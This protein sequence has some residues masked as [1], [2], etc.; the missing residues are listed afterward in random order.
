MDDLREE[1]QSPVD[2]SHSPSR[3]VLAR[4]TGDD[5]TRRAELLGSTSSDRQ[6][7]NP[8]DDETGTARTTLRRDWRFEIVAAALS[9]LV[10]LFFCLHVLHFAHRN[11]TDR[12][13]WH[14]LPF[15]KALE[16]Q[17]Y[18]L[19]DQRFSRRGPRVPLSRD[20]IAIVA[21]DQASLNRVGQWPW[22]RAMHARL[23]DRLNKAGASVVALDFD[24]SDY[25]KLGDASANSATTL[26]EAATLSANDRALVAAA[27]RAGNVIAPS[28]SDFGQSDKETQNVQ[29][30]TNLLITPFEQLDATMPDLSLAYMPLDSDGGARRYTWL[31]VFQ[32]D[33]E[34]P[35]VLG[36]FAGLAVAMHQKR[37]DGNENKAYEKALL[38]GQAQTLAGQTARVPVSR[39]RAAAADAPQM[40]TTLVHYWG[41]AGAFPT[42]SYSDVLLSRDGAYSDAA[43]KEKFAGRIVFVGATA[44]ILKDLF[45]MPQIAALSAG[46][47]TK[48]DERARAMLP[49]VELHATAAAMFLDGAF[50]RQASIGITLAS[51]FALT[52]FASLLIVLAREPVNAGARGFQTFWR[53]RNLPGRVY[54][55]SWFALYA[56]IA[57]VPVAL[58]WQGARWLFTTQN[59][60]IIVV[61]PALSAC[62]GAGGVL[63]YLFGTEAAERR[64]ALTHFSRMVSP[65]VM[66]E[67][68]A[69]P[70]EELSRPRRVRAT[71]LFTDLEG[72]TTYS[73]NHEPEEVIEALNDYLDRLVPVV[74]EYGGTID[75][76]IGDA[77]MAYFGAPVPRWDHAAQA[78]HCAIALQNEC[79][80][81]REETGIPFYMRV[82]VHTGDVI[83]GSV[84]SAQRADYTVI[85]DTV[86]LASRLEGKNKE[87]GSWIMCSTET[88]DAAPDVACVESAS[89][90]IKGK[91]RAVDVYIVRG[92]AGEAPRDKY[93]GR[94]LGSC[95]GDDA[96]TREE[97]AARRDLENNREH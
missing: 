80:R 26:G 82:G 75:K 33:S 34:T 50:I 15:W 43:L 70:E 66:D 42:Y 68:L 58:F 22:P 93:W 24:F 71:I 41:P 29:A 67:I 4:E 39:A 59:L 63:L 27:E 37:L 11:D 5:E 91:S 35:A 76:Y 25:Q 46:T 40:Q 64:K 81:F 23:I 86:N 65:D 1:T 74:Q 73:E 21:V 9:I 28:F 95:A 77:I 90:Q 47:Q 83:V 19:Y 61:Y 38:G 49:G 45:P 55:T 3:G 6:T 53:K 89:T 32:P 56:C 79:A 18:T 96:I 17:E 69:H 8:S 85:G 44:H 13:V 94:S 57:F 30:E 36:S 16:A 88:Y 78:L 7:Y 52:L 62:V 51:V 2:E 12:R 31:G 54:D 84:G 97:Q 14:A 87:F 92:L 60:W 72:F 20:K 10:S 48:K